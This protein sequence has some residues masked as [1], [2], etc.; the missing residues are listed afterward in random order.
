MVFDGR[1]YSILLVSASE[2]FNISIEKLLPE[3]A[4]SPVC[5][6]RS[7]AAAKRELSGRSFDFVIINA[8]LPDNFGAELAV[9]ICSKGN[10][11]CLI[12]VPA[13]ICGDVNA[14]VSQ[15][16]VM[17][18]PKPASAQMCAQALNWM[19]SMRERLRRLEKKSASLEDRMQEI[20]IIN[21]AKWVLI[22]SQKMSEQ[23]AHR[24]I[25]KQ[26]MDNCT[27]RLEIAR[28]IIRTCS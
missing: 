19:I 8:P 1:V 13:D 23:D 15:Q 20:R 11:V 14:K 22:D 27:T 17:T 4:F 2:K 24:Y 26:A 7:A 5:H 12:F 18:L 3:A 28:N 10:S 9:D 16:G 25:E 6:S 21:R